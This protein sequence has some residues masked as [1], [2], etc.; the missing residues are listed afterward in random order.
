MNT[1]AW[2][3]GTIASMWLSYFAF[4]TLDEDALGMALVGLVLLCIAMTVF[5]AM[6]DK[7]ILMGG[8]S[9]EDEE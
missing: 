6:A 8:K 3:A 2:L 7:H 1:V 4:E 9:D 5:G